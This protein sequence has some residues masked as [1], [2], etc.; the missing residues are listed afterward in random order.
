MPHPVAY[1][2]RRS[3]IKS[4]RRSPLGTSLR[5]RAIA[6]QRNSAGWP[7]VFNSHHFNTTPNSDY[8]VFS[9]LQPP[10]QRLLLCRKKSGA[11]SKVGGAGSKAEAEPARSRGGARSKVGAGA[12]SKPGRSRSKAGPEPLESRAEPLE[13]RGGARRKSGRSRLEAEAG[14]GFLKAACRL[15][16]R[17]H[18]FR[19]TAQRELNLP[20][21]QRRT[22]RA[23]RRIGDDR[24]GIPKFV[25]SEH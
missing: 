9:T 13:S 5:Q 1:F 8:R 21:R 22:N 4:A 15:K 3:L 16:A 11:R 12:R 20:W 7:T 23:E 2:A 24:I 25:D 10:F 18:M 17:P 6:S 19:T 14:A